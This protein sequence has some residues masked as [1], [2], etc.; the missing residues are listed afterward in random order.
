[1]S[2]TLILLQLGG[3]VALLLWGIHMIQSGIMRAYGGSLRHVFSGALH[4][5][6]KALVAGIGITAVMQSSTAAVL[7]AAGFVS[8]GL[9]EFVPAA[10][11][12]LGANVGSTLIV[13][14]L[15]FNVAAIAPVL[16]LAGVI[17]FKRGTNTRM[18]DLGR[19][20]IGLGLVMLAM[21]A[22]LLI[23]EPVEQ[24]KALKDLLA[25]LAS[26]PLMNIVIGALLTWASYSSVASVLLIMALASA[27]VI[28]PVAM[29]SLILGA[30]LGI[31]IPQYLGAGKD[32]VARRLA[33]ANV[34]MRGAGCLL[35]LPLISPIAAVLPMLGSDPARQAANFHSLFNA[36]LAVIF[37]GLLD[38]IARLCERLLP[39]SVSM[40]DPGRP[41]YLANQADGDTPGMAIANAQREV[42]RIV[43][44][45]KEMMQSFA[46][47]LGSDDRKELARVASLDDA[48]DKLHGAVKAHLVELSREEALQR[49]EARRSSEIL[50]FAINLE[51]V[52][53][54]LDMSLRELAS[55]KIKNKLR[56]APEGSLQISE[57]QARV[58]NQLAIAVSVF[59]TRNERDARILIDEKVAMRDM[60]HKALEDHL[61][62]LREGRPETI[63]TSALYLDMVRDL[64]RITAHLASV[65]YPVLE[66]RGV[67]RRSRLVDDTGT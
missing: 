9:M 20:G 40:T 62:R 8:S 44:L 28:A 52:G 60:A 4:N 59:I 14:L 21:H 67:L 39:F 58:L 7:M 65:A 18:R 6:W 38:P 66:E 36:A 34:L 37:I 16:V 26:D 27:H 19:V 29:L 15:S 12:T 10:A 55:R 41:L 23:T 13:Q 3:N 32:P 22:I 53:D 42:L 2:A 56:F 1:M 45:I 57:M 47:G 30:N 46:L 5:R 31:L 33:L 48:I 64:K 49:A 50:M 11:V 54:I 35:V 63:E 25:L 43:D 51:H 61:A 17:A 24:A